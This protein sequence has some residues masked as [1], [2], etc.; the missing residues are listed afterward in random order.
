MKRIAAALT[1][2]LLL[3]VA[4]CQPS[5]KYAGPV[6]SVQYYRDHPDEMKKLEATCGNFYPGP[7][8]DPRCLPVNQ[9]VGEEAAK[10]AEAAVAA[11]SATNSASAP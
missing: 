4:A 5:A 7:S 1:A 9:A 8:N 10:T 6:P 3:P 2:A 11:A